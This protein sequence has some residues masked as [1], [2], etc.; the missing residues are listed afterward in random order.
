MK[1]LLQINNIQFVN[2]L[3]F[4]YWDSFV[5]WSMH[6]LFIFIYFYKGIK[7]II[8]DIY[9][10]F[11]FKLQN[12]NKKYYNILFKIL[13]IFFFILNIL[14]KIFFYKVFKKYYV[15]YKLKLLKRKQKK[16][17]KMQIFLNKWEKRLK[18]I[19]KK[20]NYYIF[21]IKKNYIIFNI[22]IFKNKLI[23]L[24]LQFFRYFYYFFQFIYY[25]LLLI[26][27]FFIKLF[28]I[29]RI[30]WKNILD[31]W[32]KLKYFFFKLLIIR[33]F[34]FLTYFLNIYILKFFGFLCIF[35]I[36]YLYILFWRIIFFIIYSLYTLIFF[37]FF[38]RWVYRFMNY[39][40]FFI[41]VSQATVFLPFFF[42]IF[43]VL[44][45]LYPLFRKIW[46]YDWK[47]WLIYFFCLWLIIYWNAKWY[48]IS[49]TSWIF[50]NI[51]TYE[52]E[53][54]YYVR[55]FFLNIHYRYKAGIYLYRWDQNIYLKYELW[56]YFICRI[57]LLWFFRLWWW[58][59]MFEMNEYHTFLKIFLDEHHPWMVDHKVYPFYGPRDL[60]YVKESIW[61][62]DP[63]R[64][65]EYLW[66]INT[67]R[68][69]YVII[70]DILDYVWA[71]FEKPLNFKTYHY[72][73]D[74]EHIPFRK[75]NYWLRYR[76][77]IEIQFPNNT[78]EEVEAA[79][80]W[81]I[82]AKGWK[83]LFWNSN[84]TWDFKIKR[85]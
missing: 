59:F 11:I 41:E 23:V 53:Y 33:P 75:Y 40:W 37:I 68:R 78:F 38:L 43:C 77:L 27:K 13:K 14:N 10:L 65:F 15:T 82:A 6:W 60:G 63:A 72:N 19:K 62:R 45:C 32:F 12:R 1:E 47:D 22:L 69:S 56:N 67:D 4:V 44:Y 64:S 24:I 17:K 48:T 20:F 18:N 51:L 29:R 46:A 80:L 42:Y 25:N 74:G 84:L 39:L 30:F 8:Q 71:K 81:D 49:W 76:D 31:Y 58:G 70:F 26:I 35:F 21:L 5:L 34:N 2:I 54:G 3:D 83:S 50:K 73:E 16:L 66:F 79:L 55:T 36:Y 61:V 57:I 85:V 7:F 52:E 9:M 28:Y